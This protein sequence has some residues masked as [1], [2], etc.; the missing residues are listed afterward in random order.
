MDRLTLLTRSL[1]VS[2]HRLRA[3]TGW[4]P[5][6]PSVRQGYAEMARGH[7]SA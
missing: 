3:E 4:Q 1:R 7:S 5:R 6:Y 2:N